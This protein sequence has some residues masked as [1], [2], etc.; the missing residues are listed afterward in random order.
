MRFLR[1]SL[2]G[3]FLASL[4]LALLIVAAQMITGAVQ[5]V[6]TRDNKPPQARERVFAVTVQKAEP[7]TAP[8]I[9]KHLAK[10]KAAGVWNCGRRWAAASSGWRKTSRMAGL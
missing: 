8:P 3:V 2:I 9:W 4:M 6:M 7:Q 1:Q 5:E 10:F